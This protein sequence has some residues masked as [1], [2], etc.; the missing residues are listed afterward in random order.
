[1]V[2]SHLGS[3]ISDIKQAGLNLN[4]F[5]AVAGAFSNKSSKKTEE[6]SSSVETKEDQAKIMGQGDGHGHGGAAAAGAARN[7]HAKEAVAGGDA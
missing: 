2:H 7:A 6:D 3:N 4:I 5:G 1:M